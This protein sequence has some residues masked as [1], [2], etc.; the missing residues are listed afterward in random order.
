MTP[1]PV[2][3]LAF[4]NDS[5][6]C[7]TDPRISYTFKEAGEYLV[8]VKDV[9]NRGGAEFFYRLRIGDFPLATTPFPMA[10]KRSDTAKINFAGPAVENVS[11]GRCRHPQ[12]SGGQRRVGR[13]QG[14]Q[15]ASRLAGASQRQ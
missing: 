6:G 8:E 5:P 15:R 9:L 4:D 2:R 1:R 10:A 3:D 14:R 11:A 13:S 12:R 7:Q